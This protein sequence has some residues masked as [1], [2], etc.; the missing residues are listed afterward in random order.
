M[1]TS[2][3]QDKVL[4]QIHA[5]KVH[6]RPRMYFIVRIGALIGIAAAAFL[7]AVFLASFVMFAIQESGSASLLSFGPRGLAIFFSLFPWLILGVV[8]A[9]LILMEFLFRS[10][11]IGYS[12][13]VLRVFAGVLA[14]AVIGSTVVFASPL[15]GKLLERADNDDLPVVGALYKGTHVSHKDNGVFRGVVTSLAS[16]SF[17]ISHDDID[18]DSDDG[19]WTVTPS[20]ISGDVSPK[21]G[22]K[23]YVAGDAEG[24]VIRAYG[25]RKLPTRV[26]DSS[27]K[28]EERQTRQQNMEQRRELNMRQNERQNVEQTKVEDR[29]QNKGQNDERF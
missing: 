13:P 25:V 21:V 6:M 24:G 29:R 7:V 27:P 17:T 9:L 18:R 10:F 2:N 11:K 5:G 14:L 22:D 23:V 4:E 8:F 1:N 15:H 12:T 20:N 16:S 3:I 26:R 28:R 19:T